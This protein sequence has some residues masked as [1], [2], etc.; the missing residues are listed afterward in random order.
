VPR[1]R[2]D[3]PAVGAAVYR[4]TVMHKRLIPFRHKFDYRVFSLLVDLDRLPE[5][6]RRHRLFGHNRMALLSLRDRDHGPRDGSPLKPWVAEQVRAAGGGPI[7]QVA[8]LAFP[9]MWGYAFNPLSVYY[10]ADPDGTLAWIVHE[11]RN[12]FGDMRHYVLPVTDDGGPLTDR[13]VPDAGVR[14]GVSADA[15]DTVI[16]QTCG[17]DFYVSPFIGMESAYRF[18]LRAPDERLSLLIR[19]SVPE[20][21]LLL[22]TLTGRR[23]AFS[24]AG[25]LGTVA[26]YPALGW[27]VMAAIHWEALR[28]WRKGA[29]YH[30]R[31]RARK[32]LNSASNGH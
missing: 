11:V 16:R 13:G 22:A 21:E 30:P 2:L 9:R 19:Q 24:D 27:K 20:G 18:R 3:L 15:G 14:A 5:L 31:P 7:G 6:D 17:K 28:L 10:V 4:G 12:T 23:H 32:A 8:L 1:P 25:I 26:R 29:R